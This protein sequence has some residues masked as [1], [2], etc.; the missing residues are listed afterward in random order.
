MPWRRAVR[1]GQGL[2]RRQKTSE[3]RCEQIRVD[4][5]RNEVL[6]GKAPVDRPGLGKL[7]GGVSQADRYGNRERQLWRESR[8]P[9]LLLRNLAYIV[10]GAW[11]TQQVVVTEVKR[12]VVPTTSGDS[13]DRQVGKLRK[14]PG[15]KA[16]RE[17]PV[18]RFA[19]RATV[20]HC[21]VSLRR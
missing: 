13:P 18:D 14:L 20:T 10:R 12:A 15:N 11:E 2:Q 1:R 3:V 5:C 19:F 17:T 8:Q 7:I 4:R 6:A 9:S 16:A 21:A